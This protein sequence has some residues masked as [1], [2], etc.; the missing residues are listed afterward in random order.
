MPPP[1][2]MMLTAHDSHTDFIYVHIYIIRLIQEY[3]TLF[4]SSIHLGLKRIW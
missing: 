2:V 1:P 4:F 3:H